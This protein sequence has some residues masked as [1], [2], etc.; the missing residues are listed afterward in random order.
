MCGIAGFV[1]NAENLSIQDPEKILRRMTDTLRHRGPD[2][3][4]YVI[5]GPAALGHRRLSIIDLE[6]GAQPMTTPDGNLTIVFNGEIYNFKTIR[7]R[8]ERA[9][10]AFIT[11]SDTEVL[12]HAYAEYGD[13]CLD[14]LNGMFA[15]AIWDAPRKRLFAARD[16][17]GQKPLYYALRKGQLL[18]ASELKAL[19]PHPRLQ[20]RMTPATLAR[21]LAHG[22]LPAPHTIYDDV[23]K[24][25]PGHKLIYE[26]GALRTAPYWRIDFHRENLAGLDA[27]QLV[28]RFSD[29]FRNAVDLRL[30]SDVPLGV[31]LS[32]GIDSSAVVA[33]MCDILPPRNVKTFSI[34]FVEKSHDESQYAR[35]VA[36]HFG[37]DHYEKTL[38][39]DTLLERLPTLIAGMDEPFADASLSPT[40][41]VSEF[42]RARVTVALGG[43]GGDELFAG[44][45]T[46]PLDRVAAPYALLPKPVRRLWETPAHWA[47]D[48]LNLKRLRRAIEYIGRAADAPPEWRVMMWA[49]AAAHPAIQRRLL[50]HPDPA[51]TDPHFLYAEVIA[52]HASAPARSRL[53]QLQ[54]QFQR[55]YLPDD[56][57]TKVDRASMAHSL[58]VRA[59]FMD[60]RIVDFVNALPDRW[61]LRGRAGKILLKRFLHNKLPDNILNRP[62]QGF[63]IPLARWLRSGLRARMENALQENALREQDLFRPEFLQRLWREHLSGKRDHSGLLW[64]FLA[65]QLWWER[66]RPTFARRT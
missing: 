33:A 47:F 20:P 60:P 31:F 54:Y 63:G 53:A 26:N 1:E 10:H 36:T 39:L 57:L 55:E 46:F 50:A 61:K 58:E 14:H 42:A 27:G 29:L 40:S 30:V 44:Y 22:Y 2:D 65:F 13:A 34:A 66:W 3:E 28:R 35:Q 41:L 59:P 25:L 17:M 16:R 23:F 56:I 24:L 51:L 52:H 9:G 37:T 45:S 5:R 18:F 4:G 32:G 8:L 49:E 6:R 48:R 19:L 38:D 64:T 21:Y 62:K 11:N 15:F 43:D 12:L 7:A